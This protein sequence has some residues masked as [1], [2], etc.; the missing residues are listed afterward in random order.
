MSRREVSRLTKYVA[1][2]ETGPC[3]STS[4]K[5]RRLV[6]RPLKSLGV[7]VETGDNFT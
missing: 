4:G 7:N 6:R 3:V 2:A 1:G 5:I